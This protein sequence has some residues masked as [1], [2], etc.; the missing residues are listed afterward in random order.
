MATGPRSLLYLSSP[1]GFSDLTREFMQRELQPL[2]VKRGFHVLNPWVLNHDLDRELDAIESKKTA[3]AQLLA[4]RKITHSIGATNFAAIDACDLVLAV[5]DGV[6]VDSG[7]AAEVG[8]A[9]RAGKRI[10]GLLTDRRVAHCGTAL[11]NVT[12]QYIVEASGGQLFTG[13]GELRKAWKPRPGGTVLKQ[14]PGPS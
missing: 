11:C 14:I 7:V 8:Y 1:L 13:L 2:L 6:D 3:A 10:H 12:L 4:T 5:F 9:Y